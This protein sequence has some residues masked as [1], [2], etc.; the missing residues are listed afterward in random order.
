MGS[1]LSS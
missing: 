1:Y